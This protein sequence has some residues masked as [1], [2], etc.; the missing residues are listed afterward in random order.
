MSAY[1]AAKAAPTTN[2]YFLENSKFDPR[3]WLQSD[4]CVEI[5]CPINNVGAS[6]SGKTQ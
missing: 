4:P 6:A 1:V 2:G 3:A 5:P